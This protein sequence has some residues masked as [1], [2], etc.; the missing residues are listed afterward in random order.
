VKRE[1]VVAKTLSFVRI[2]RVLEKDINTARTRIV[3]IPKK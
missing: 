1:V 2:G 3:S